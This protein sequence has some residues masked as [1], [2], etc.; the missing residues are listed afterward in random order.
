M[1]LSG[2]HQ[3]Q[4]HGNSPQRTGEGGGGPRQ[5]S[6]EVNWSQPFTSFMRL[7]S[8]SRKGQMR[9]PGGQDDAAAPRSDPSG[10]GLEGSS[11]AE[12][13]QRSRGGSPVVNYDSCYE[14]IRIK[15][16][17][18]AYCTWSHTLRLCMAR[19]MAEIGQP[20]VRFGLVRVG[21]N[22]GPGRTVKDW[23]SSMDW[24]PLWGICRKSSRN[25][26]PGSNPAQDS[27]ICEDVN[28]QKRVNHAAYLVAHGRLGLLIVERTATRESQSATP[29]CPVAFVI[30]FRYLFF[31][32]SSSGARG[33]SSLTE[34]E[35]RLNFK[36]NQM[37]QIQDD[38]IGRRNSSASVRTIES[39]AFDEVRVRRCTVDEIGG[40]NSG[41]FLV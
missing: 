3:L 6:D 25:S 24:T 26:I 14:A 18:S 10:A 7:Q 23:W 38:Q 16:E 12:T 41:F 11:R 33:N 28:T 37:F 32:V 30:I 29:K 19:H 21:R 8:G 40:Y 17:A 1:T 22:Q 35:R 5:R 2:D 15:N 4:P 13:H 34:V 27:G 31:L 20:P 39:G 36:A 9:V